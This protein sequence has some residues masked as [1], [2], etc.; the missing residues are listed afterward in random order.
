MV[1]IDCEHERIDGTT[2]VTCRLATDARVRVTVEPTH[3]GPVWPP[4]RQGVPAPGWEDGAWTGVVRADAPR[5]LGYATPTAL[6]AG[7]DGAGDDA[8]E[9]GAGDADGETGDSEADNESG[10]ADGQAPAAITAVEPAEAGD[11]PVSARD[12]IRALGDPSPARDAVP[13]PATTGSTGGRESAENGRSTGE[14]RDIGA[15]ES[16]DR[17]D[18]EDP[19]PQDRTDIEDPKSDDEPDDEGGAP[20][21]STRD[22]DSVAPGRSDQV[23][24]AARLD[25]IDDRLQTA[26]TLAAVSTPEEARAAVSDAGG[27]AAVRALVEQLEADRAYL[28]RV[29]ER[30][31]DLTARAEETTVP[32]AALERLA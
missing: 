1:R 3:E 24:G 20:G 18:S 12:V 23:A 7:E 10:D 27:L 14:R 4:R 30:T 25:A 16:D 19:K 32:L 15:P 5:G 22:E 26:A 21:D 2:L 29:S 17:R 13:D 11:G 6:G 28:R 9:D 31:G 8:S